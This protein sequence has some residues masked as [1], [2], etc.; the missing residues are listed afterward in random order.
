MRRKED[1]PLEKVTLNLRWGDFG[2]LQ[3]LYPRLGAGRIIR[4]LVIA[5]LRQR[6][7]NPQMPD[8]PP[9]DAEMEAAVNEILAEQDAQQA[10]DRT[11]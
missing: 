11:G 8:M 2:L 1:Y 4:A 9:L 5:H 7:V 3:K 6:G 10:L